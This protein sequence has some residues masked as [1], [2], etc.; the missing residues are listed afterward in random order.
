VF[1]AYSSRR[2]ASLQHLWEIE[3]TQAKLTAT[4]KGKNKEGSALTSRGI[5]VRIF[6]TASLK[7]IVARLLGR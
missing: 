7:I 6:R 1:E 4:S 5:Q 2:I 3:K